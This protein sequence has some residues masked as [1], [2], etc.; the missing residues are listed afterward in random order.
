MNCMHYGA[1]LARLWEHLCCVFSAAPVFL[2]GRP[3]VHVENPAVARRA[4]QRRVGAAA[5]QHASARGRAGSWNHRS[6]C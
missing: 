4:A 5:L 6:C 2:A 1:L 3:A